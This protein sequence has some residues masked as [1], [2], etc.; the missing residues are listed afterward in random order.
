[1]PSR[2]L[3]V[4]HVCHM[5]FDLCADMHIYTLLWLHGEAPP[6][7]SH[8]DVPGRS[9]HMH[10]AVCPSICGNMVCYSVTIFVDGVQSRQQG[11]TLMVLSHQETATLNSVSAAA[12]ETRMPV[13]AQP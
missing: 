5:H 2:R 13:R 3:E 11:T 1:M 10:G 8:V 9:D 4:F 6:E 12:G 7:R